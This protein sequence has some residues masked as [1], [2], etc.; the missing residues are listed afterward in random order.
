MNIAI[1]YA[2][3][4]D[5]GYNQ[6]ILRSVLSG[7]AQS[8]GKKETEEPKHAVTLLDL[9]QEGF[10]PVLYF[11][12]EHRR[13][14]LKNDPETAKYRTIITQADLLV[15]IYPIWWS[16]MPAIL[17]GFIDRVFAKGFAYQ[18]RGLLPQGLLKGK[19]AWII[20]TSDTPD[21]YARLFEPDYGKVL[22]HQ[23]L[24]IMCGVK[25]IKHHQMNYLRGSSFERRKRFL[26]EVHDFAAKL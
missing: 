1:F 25:T 13:R 16:S 2:Y 10:N 24:G 6:A 26:H 18:Y 7:F 17:K 19:K 11:D 9:Y 5:R 15:F 23:I 4:N 22:Q 14:N 8:C 3:P 20:T 12:Q 21:F